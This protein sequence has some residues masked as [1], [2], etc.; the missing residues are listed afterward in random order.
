MVRGRPGPGAVVSVR[1]HGNHLPSS[2]AGGP[3]RTTGIGHGMYLQA[4]ERP[5]PYRGQEFIYVIASPA[6]I[7]SMGSGGP[8]CPSIDHRGHGMY[9]YGTAAPVLTD[10]FRT[11]QL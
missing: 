7:R 5:C 3:C 2:V 4:N 10:R 8:G 1:S 11:A 9:C 6:V